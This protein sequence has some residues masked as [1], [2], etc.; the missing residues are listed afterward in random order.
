MYDIYELCM[1]FTLPQGQGSH[2]PSNISLVSILQHLASPHWTGLPSLPTPAGL[3]PHS[4]T[5]VT[6]ERREPGKK[7]LWPWRGW[8][9]ATLCLNSFPRQAEHLAFPEKLLVQSKKSVGSVA[10]PDEWEWGWKAK[11]VLNFKVGGRVK[12]ERMASEKK[13]LSLRRRGGS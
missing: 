13:P 2:Q 3:C 6:T 1:N 12:E 4:S 5:T 8:K 7:P 10:A 11:G 9:A